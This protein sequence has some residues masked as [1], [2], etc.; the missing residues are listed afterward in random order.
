[1]A[2]FLEQLVLVSNHSVKVLV[3]PDGAT[4]ADC[5]INDFDV[6]DFQDWMIRSNLTP[7][8][9]WTITWT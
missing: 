3:L 9:G 8:E 6:N 2:D 5:L 1:M 7:S 4:L